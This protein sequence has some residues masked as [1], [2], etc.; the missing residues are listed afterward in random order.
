[1]G[2][3]CAIS[4]DLDEIACY[5]AIH[6]LSGAKSAPRAVYDIALERLASW[7]RELG[8]PLTLFVVGR[9][10]ENDRNQR[11]LSVLHAVGFEL[12]NH[13]LDHRYDLTRLSHAK[14]REQ[15]KGGME[16]LQEIL[17]PINVGFRAP[18]YLVNDALLQVV[19]ESGA[20]YDSSVFPCP[21]YYVAKALVIGVQRLQGRHS[22]S[23][24]DSPRVLT[25]LTRPYRIGFPYFQRGEGLWEVPIQVTPG[26]RLPFIGTA[27]TTLGEHGARL[28]TRLL[29]QEAWVNLELHGIDFLDETD[30][31]QALAVHQPDLR[32]AW[33]KKRARLTAVVNELKKSGRNFVCLKEAVLRFGSAPSLLG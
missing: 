9:D 14:M 31:L 32:V 13:S 20:L 18:G 23:L 4:V 16:R 5:Y 30:D 12:A 17:G 26:L 2:G 15:V 3:L 1:M 25:A 11:R 7:A 19:H 28:Y 24:V 6:G 22:F 10:L 8:I 33:L 29:R 21:A 27:L